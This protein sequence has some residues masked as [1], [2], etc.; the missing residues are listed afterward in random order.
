M[1]MVPLAPTVD[2]VSEGV[3]VTDSVAENA[4]LGEM[5]IEWG[6]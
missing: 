1:E 3:I 2:C 6:K 4:P 5:G